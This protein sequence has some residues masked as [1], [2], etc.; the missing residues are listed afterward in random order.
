MRQ[1]SEKLPGEERML[2][3]NYELEH[4]RRMDIINKPFPKF[5]IFKTSYAGASRGIT[6]P[7][8]PLS[9][10]AQISGSFAPNK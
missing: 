2:P 1:Y 4:I 8:A 10:R 7:N 3:M 5:N 9:E 6:Y